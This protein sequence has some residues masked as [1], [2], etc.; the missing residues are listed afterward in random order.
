MFFQAE[1]HIK[2]ALEK[3]F[4]YHNT[5]GDG[6]SIYLLARRTT[7][8]SQSPTICREIRLELE[9]LKEGNGIPREI[10]TGPQIKEEVL[11]LEIEVDKSE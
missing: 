11:I 6:D 4:T 3:I 9:L 8:H 10:C 1:V 7:V 2:L 5:D